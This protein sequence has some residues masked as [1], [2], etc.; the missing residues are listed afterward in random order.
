MVAPVIPGLNDS[1]MPAILA[2]AREAGA[3]WAG[4][5]LLKLP[6]TVK[7][8]F[9]DWLRRTYPDRADRV[10]S[11]I[12]STRAGRLSDSQFGRRQVGTGNFAELIA[13]TFELWTKKLG[14][15][16]EHGKLNAE[17]FISPLPAKGQM[18]LF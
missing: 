5:V 10:E 6:T 17:A 2:A 13:D 9:T 7:D 16:E 12:R 18:R 11:L 4:Y 15:N 14:F 3:Q 8:V 1:E